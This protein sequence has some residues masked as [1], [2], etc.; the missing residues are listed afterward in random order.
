VHIV[1][2]YVRN[3][4]GFLITFNGTRC[5][6][7]SGDQRMGKFPMLERAAEKQRLMAVIRLCTCREGRITSDETSRANFVE[8]PLYRAQKCAKG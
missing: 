6:V 3:V 4:S 5:N 8:G 1:S 2:H 7:I